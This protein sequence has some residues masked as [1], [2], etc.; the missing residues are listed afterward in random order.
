MYEP[1]V[2]TQYMNGSGF[3][4]IS[5]YLIAPEETRRQINVYTGGGGGV[6][7]VTLRRGVR[8]KVRNGVARSLC[9]VVGQYVIKIVV[10]QK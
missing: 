1:A 9:E 7:T 5:V 3:I 2:G 10:S 4:R 6:Y 8:I